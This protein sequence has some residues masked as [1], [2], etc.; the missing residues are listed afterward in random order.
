MPG[1]GMA[2]FN[3]RKSLK[4]RSFAQPKAAISAH[5][6]DPHETD[7]KAMTSGSPEIMAGVTGPQIWDDVEGR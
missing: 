7:T 2:C 6:L 4:R 3:F 5:E 1:D